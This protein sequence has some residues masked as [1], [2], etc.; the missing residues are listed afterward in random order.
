MGR[1]GT[2]DADHRNPRIETELRG[3]RSRS[4]AGVGHSSGQQQ[5]VP[6]DPD[7][8]GCGQVGRRV[9]DLGPGSLE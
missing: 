4:R 7:Q 9:D 6:R 5:P 8:E 3:R 1:P 2:L